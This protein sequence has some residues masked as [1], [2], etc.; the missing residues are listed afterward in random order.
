MSKLLSLAIRSLRP[1]DFL[2]RVDSHI[3][4]EIRMPLLHHYQPRCALTIT[5]FNSMKTHDDLNTCLL[6]EPLEG[7]ER[8]E[9]YRPGAYHP[10]QI[11]DHFHGRYRVVHKLGH[12]SYSTTWLARDERS[13]KYVAVKVCTADSN[14]KEVEIISTLTRPHCSPV[15]NPGKTMV[16]SILDRL[17]IHGPNGNHVC[18]VAAPARA[19]LSGVKDGSWIRLFQLDVA[20]SLAAQLILVVDYVHAQGIIHGDFHLGNILL[21]IPPKFDQLSLE[22]LYEKAPGPTCRN[23]SKKCTLMAR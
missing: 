13:N 16:P 3:L 6:Y 9:N 8:L 2:S 7:V 17:T 19:S 5:A 4:R 20:R 10:I 22:Q 12:G 23:G 11:G 21:K 1:H 15:N 14:P 18:Y